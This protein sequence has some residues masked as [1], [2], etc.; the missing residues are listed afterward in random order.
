MD[1]YSSTSVKGTPEKQHLSEVMHAVQLAVNNSFEQMK[2]DG[3]WCGELRSNAT[4][5]AEYVF[6]RA[7]LGLDLTVDSAALSKWLWAE[8]KADG[9]WGIAPFY[10]GDVS[11]TTE[12]YLALKI[13][14]TPMDHPSMARAREFIRSAGGVAKVRIFTRIYLATFGLFP[15]DVVPQL[16]PEFILMRSWAPIN[17]YHLSSWARSTVVP[18]LILSH[19]RP[20]FALPNGRS[21]CNDFLDELWCDPTNKMVPYSSGT[22]KLW[23]N[24]RVGCVFAVADNI[25]HS[26]GGLSKRIPLRSLARR[27]C[28]AWIL[29]HQEQTGDWAG[30]FPPM[31]LSIIA[32]MLEG[33]SLQGSAIQRGLAAV[34]A[35]AWIDEGGKRMQAC[36]S[37]VWD[38]LL[39][40]TALCDAGVRV[41][42]ERLCQAVR[43]VQARQVFGPEG[44]WRIFRPHMTGG[45]FSFEYCNN[46]YPDVDDTAEAVLT[47]LKQDPRSV[48]SA[49]VIVAVGWILGMQNKDG[50]W[51]AFDWGNNKLFLNKIPFS[52]MDSLC[53]PSTADV[54]GHVLEMFG[55]LVQCAAGE[56]RS[57]SSL[58]Q[59][60]DDAA[61]R[62]I[63]Y[64]A[65]TQ[66]PSGAWFGRWGVNYIYGTSNV[67]LPSLVGPA[68]KWL[69]YV[70]HSD[71]SW[72]EALDS[73]GVG[74]SINAFEARQCG[75]SISTPSQTAW[76]IMGLL[77]HFPPTDLAI[78]RGITNLLHTQTVRSGESATWPEE[79]YT[80][81]GFP[82]FFYIG[83]AMY[84]HYFPLMALG[85]Y[86]SAVNATG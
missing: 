47:F 72:G 74:P 30:I 21:S 85:R 22:R 64:L 16:P 82:K 1:L 62:A 79:A 78:Q 59:R 65:S 49:S 46:W 28:V 40:T 73:Y 11:T 4:I 3:H 57:A 20:I 80:G 45:G 17:I 53:D 84:S 2:P 52:D 9:S 81:T 68:I 83:Y 10:P 5:T 76:G 18:L 32:L 35:F 61:T 24:D 38:T 23:K 50:G 67:L 15:W 27:R 19:H 86:V 58:M 12:A 60:V 66:E 56:D 48:G 70:Q 55:L 41:Q 13:L 8:Q 77:A 26:L 54:T 37:P 7:A 75:S 31:H 39:M 14:G 63:S 34:E 25:L 33:F 43:W 36:V 29:E 51:A 69:R 71:G 42:D 6:L 44:D